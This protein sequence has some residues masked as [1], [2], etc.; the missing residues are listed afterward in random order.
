MPVR[1]RQGKA[2]E[3]RTISI[4]RTEEAIVVSE[5][6]N[7][8][9]T[10]ATSPETNKPSAD[11]YKQQ[12]ETVLNNATV[13]L[14]IMDEHQQCS[15][16]NPAAEALTGFTFAEVQGR[17]LH[18]M[19]HHTRPDGTP[20]P[21][22]E[23]PIDR[24]F[25]EN[26]QE[27]GEEIFVHK[28][29]TFYPVAYTASPICEAGTVVG[30]IIE[31]RDIA[32]EK[33]DQEA[34]EALTRATRQ[35]A[36]QFQQLAEAAITI[37]STL[38]LEATLQRVT[39][40][41]RLIIGAHQSVTSL[42]TDNHWSQAITAVS[43]SDKYAAWREYHVPTDGS[44]IYTIVCRENRPIRMT[45]AELEA[46]TAWRG[47]GTEHRRHPPMRG[48]L[49]APLTRPDGQNIGLIQLSDKYSGE[50]TAQDEAILV[51]L[52]QLASSAIEHARLY[53]EARAAI[54]IR[55]QFLSIAAHELR[56][57]LTS[58]LGYVQLLQRRMQR[59]G[60]SIDQRSERSLQQIVT[61]AL[62]LN[63]LIESLLDVVRIQSGR[64]AIERQPIDL[65]HLLTGVV[66][67][68][69]LTTT[70]HHL[71]L[72]APMQRLIVDGDEL[73][74]AQVFVNLIQNALKYSPHGGVIDITITQ[75]G[76]QACVAVRDQGIGIP[77][78]AIGQLFQRFYRVGGAPMQHISGM[79]IGLYVVKE[80]VSLH[81]GTV[82]VESVE[83]VGST[84]TVCLPLPEPPESGRA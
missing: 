53:A 69:L 47:F 82:A 11:H 58:L 35:Q 26:N 18:D 67:E 78:A 79:G 60:G 57:P 5:H 16:M 38:S 24:A 7:K 34:R 70:T 51:Q 44:G 77:E 45:Q 81:G 41:A 43:L 68:L 10:V 6:G 73:R 30:T 50:F 54:Q 22:E 61:Q 3:R 8:A 65:Q 74:L 84:F 56:T 14:F 9:A 32:R 17:A 23:C 31:V 28:N 52:A 55:E 66:D 20:Y 25:P 49:A 33:A 63:K 80:I 37:N 4:T 15:Y 62:R 64:L 12:L 71:R 48:W 83:G 27:Q 21:L 39:E 36:R 75:Q 29:G 76:A 19:I 13:A 59:S 2:L 72:H 40:H 42:T 1:Q 46:H